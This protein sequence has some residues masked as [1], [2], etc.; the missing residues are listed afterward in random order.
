MFDIFCE[1]KSMDEL[2]RYIVTYYPNLMTIKEKAAYKASLG[3]EKAES[4]EPGN[5][6][7][8]TR[9]SWGSRDPEVLALLE[10][11]REE[12]LRR[13]KDKILQEHADEVFLNYCPRCGALTRTPTAKQC[14]KCFFSWHGDV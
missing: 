4:L 6:Q 13:V 7:R 12:F 5:F 1:A 9:E 2:T 10:N 11:G 3:E 14:P 8:I